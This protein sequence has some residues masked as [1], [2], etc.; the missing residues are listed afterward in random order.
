M[1]NKFLK[2]PIT[3]T[4][5]AKAFIETLEKENLLFHFDDD[6]FDIIDM[7]NKRTFTDEEAKLIDE[8]VQELFDQEWGEFEDP[9]GYALYLMRDDD[10]ER[11]NGP[12]YN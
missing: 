11:S 2:K 10:D 3:T 7:D 8:R 6:P 4:Q 12:S 5:E 9:H 1:K